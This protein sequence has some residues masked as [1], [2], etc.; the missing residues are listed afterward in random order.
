MKF[1]RWFVLAMLL[2]AVPCLPQS[3]ASNTSSNTGSA[4]YSLTIANPTVQIHLNSPINV[5]IT[6]KNVSNDDIYWRAELGNS[7]YHAFHFSLRK[8]GRE[9]ETTRFHRIVRNEM[10]PDDQPESTEG[11]GS[12]IVSALQPGK[13]F[14][15]TVDLNKLYKITESGQYTLEI[16]RTEE[17][18]KITVHSNKIT[19]QVLP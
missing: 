19:L 14:T 2:A 7:A 15:L 12:S 16:S 18:S 17:D 8:E 4:G 11:S 5:A 3:G 6:V 1:D 10:R 9:V 13:S